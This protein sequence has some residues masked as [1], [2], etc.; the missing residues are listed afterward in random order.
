MNRR[1]FLSL[2]GISSISLP[3]I[4]KTSGDYTSQD[5]IRDMRGMDNTEH[6]L[7]AVWIKND[8]GK[9]FR[10]ELIDGE[11]LIG[12]EKIPCERFPYAII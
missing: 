9:I 11:F 8:Q 4:A 6:L 1:K 10:L 5:F 7:Q 3:V 12:N 2:L